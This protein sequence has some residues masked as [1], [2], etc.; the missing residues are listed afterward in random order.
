MA[1]EMADIE[2]VKVDVDD[3]PGIAEKCGITS[4]PTFQFY[5]E[6]EKMKGFSGADEQ[7]I[8]SVITELS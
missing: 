7:Q 8:R 4:M 1:D 6:G 3:A 2:F 5:K